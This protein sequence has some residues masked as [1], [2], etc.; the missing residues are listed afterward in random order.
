MSISKLK[1]ENLTET[2]NAIFSGFLATPSVKDA[3]FLILTNIQAKHPKLRLKD[4]SFIS[5]ADKENN[6]FYVNLTY[7]SRIIKKVIAKKDLKNIELI[8]LE[9]L[10]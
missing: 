9:L 4:I 10:K 7:N 8:L 2:K 6:F 5:D 3:L 1:Y